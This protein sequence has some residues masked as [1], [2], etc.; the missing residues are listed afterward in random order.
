MIRLD[1][2]QRFDWLRLART[3]GVGPIGFRSLINRFGGARPALDA[4]PE[5]ARAKGRRVELPPASAIEAEFAA[6]DAIGARFL[7][8]GET[9]YPPRLHDLD[10]PPPVLAVLGRIERLAAPAVA[11][12][13][14]RNASAAGQRLAADFA[15]GLGRAGY[16]IVSG[17]ARGIDAAAHRASLGTGTVGVLAGG[18]DRPYPPENT[19]LFE[20]IAAEGLFVTEMPFGWAPRGRDFPRRNRLISGLSRGTLVVEAAQRSGSLITARMAAEQGREVF[21]I[22]GSPLDPRSEGTNAL[23]RGGATLVTSP[24]EVVE[25]LRAFDGEAERMPSLFREK[26]DETAEPLFDDFLAGIDSPDMSDEPPSDTV[27]AAPD[28][29]ALLSV[30]PVEID[31]LGRQSGLSPAALRERLVELEIEGLLVRLPGNC[32]ARA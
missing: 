19:G 29:L 31:E 32:V 18:L 27:P 26:P 9:G 21:A 13:G 5:L 10:G 22:P 20:S 28:L 6:A 3:G 17:Y 23:L 16:T 24:A 2:R 1:D 30:T 7:C 11:I 12:V 8:S 25:A 15:A 4:L 14:S